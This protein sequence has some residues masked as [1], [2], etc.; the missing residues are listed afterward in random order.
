MDA[1]QP[2]HH[3]GAQGV[4]A[5]PRR[6]SACASRAGLTSLLPRQVNYNLFAVN[7]AMAV[8]GSYQLYRKMM[9]E[10]GG[11]AAAAL[12]KLE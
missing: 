4:P 5:P 11:G 1:L 12:P 2:R 10:Y 7:A 3:A 6:G 8:T 9:H